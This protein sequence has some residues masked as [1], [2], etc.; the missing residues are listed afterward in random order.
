MLLLSFISK[1]R[2]YLNSKAVKCSK[3]W[4]QVNDLISNF[5][6]QRL[7]YLIIDFDLIQMTNFPHD[8]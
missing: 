5:C 6:Y 8:H 4:P 7:N 2:F 3:N 1:Y